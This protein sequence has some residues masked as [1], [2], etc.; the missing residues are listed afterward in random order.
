MLPRSDDVLTFTSDVS[1]LPV[2]RGDMVHKSPKDFGQTFNELSHTTLTTNM[3]DMY[4]SSA[5]LLPRPKAPSTERVVQ[6]AYD[7]DENQYM[8]R[9]P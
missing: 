9:F 7:D 1:T 4:A 5:L 3:Q 6:V 2:P 8:P